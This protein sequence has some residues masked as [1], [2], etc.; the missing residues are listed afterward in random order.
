MAEKYLV[1]PIRIFLYLLA[2]VISLFYSLCLFMATEYG[3]RFIAKNVFQDNLNFNE[4][5][6]QPSLLGIKINMQDFYYRGA[7][8]FYGEEL[9][10]EIN[11]L[12]SVISNHI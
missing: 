8:D 12:N 5:K 11:F 9:A 2:I 7:A 3:A 6:V 1:W 4:I 10:L